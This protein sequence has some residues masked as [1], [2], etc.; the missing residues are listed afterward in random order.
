MKG[1]YPNSLIYLKKHNL[2]LAGSNNSPSENYIIFMRFSPDENSDSY[3]LDFQFNIQTSDKVTRIHTNSSET[4][5][6][7]ALKNENSCCF[8]IKKRKKIHKNIEIKAMDGFCIWT[9]NKFDILMDGS[10]LEKV[11]NNPKM[12]K[13]LPV[14]RYIWGISKG[15]Y[16][17]AVEFITLDINKFLRIKYWTKSMNNNLKIKYQ[18]ILNNI[19]K[20]KSGKLSL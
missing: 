18:K 16:Y 14:I 19:L 17:K 5:I 15:F 10:L 1:I 2:F 6:I 13:T 4:K 12:V 3:V 7:L 20:N 9:K 8:E 11:K